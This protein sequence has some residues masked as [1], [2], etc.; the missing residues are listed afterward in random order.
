VTGT[1]TEKYI[2]VR[3]VFQLFKSSFTAVSKRLKQEL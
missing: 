3:V 2:G 1:Q